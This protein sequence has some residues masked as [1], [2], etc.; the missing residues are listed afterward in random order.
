MAL[1]KERV[2][3]LDD[4]GRTPTA[5]LVLSHIAADTSAE[6]GVNA[7]NITFTENGEGTANISGK[8]KTRAALISFGQKL[9]GDATFR[10]ASIPVSDLA[11]D[12]NIDFDI[13]FTFSIYGP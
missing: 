11:E 13:P 5:A 8:A 1:L 10:G 2:T 3:L 9:Q 12:S 7:I 4:Y 6:I